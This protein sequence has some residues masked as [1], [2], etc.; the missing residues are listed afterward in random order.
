MK[1]R[2]FLTLFA[3][4]PFFGAGA[5]SAKYA[6]GGIASSELMASYFGELHVGEAIIPMPNGTSIPVSMTSYIGES[7]NV[8]PAFAGSGM[9]SPKILKGG[10]WFKI[11][12]AN[13]NPIIHL[14]S[15][16]V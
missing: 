1:R 8:D 3:G 7:I 6:S 11:D 12:S 14:G 9:N 13:F 4:L 5:A 15:V 2:S 10:E 16:S